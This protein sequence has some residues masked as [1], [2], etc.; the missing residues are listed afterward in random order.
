MTRH[1]LEPVTRQLAR[2]EVVAAHGVECVDQLAPGRH[3]TNAASGTVVEAHAT[4]C[5]SLTQ[6]RLTGAPKRERDTKPPRTSL[7]KWQIEA[8]Q[9]VVLDDIRIRRLNRRYE[10]SDQLRFARVAAIAGLEEFRVACRVADRNHEHAIT[11]GVEARRLEIE[12]QPP[13]LIV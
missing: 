2:R 9:V 1:G 13:K 5:G 8:V 10:S 4:L 11:T 12:L 3:Q 7:E 6:L